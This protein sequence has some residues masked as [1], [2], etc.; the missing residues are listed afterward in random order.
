MRRV[1]HWSAGF[2]GYDVVVFTG[3][4]MS[5]GLVRRLRDCICAPRL[6][7]KLG[8]IVSGRIG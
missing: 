3:Y 1:R 8:D 5:I 7:R 6:C 4:S 2:T